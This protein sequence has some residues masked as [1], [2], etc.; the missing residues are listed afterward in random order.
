LADLNPVLVIDTRE[1]DPL[2]FTRLQSIKGTL[3]S[4]DYSV[5]GLESLIAIERKSVSDLVG[6]CI[7]RNR[8]RLERE[9]HRLRGFRFKRFLIVGTEE[10]ILRGNFQS[11]IKPKAVL[12]TLSAF[13]VRYDVPVVF[14]E[15]P[16]AAPR[17]IERWSFWFAR[18]V[19]KDANALP[20]A[21][22]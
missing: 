9:L 21:S 3:Y 12:A 22:T 20:K 17:Q 16:E 5:R 15:K 7:G 14:C 8:E 10:Q 6:C 4:G 1:Q 13:E 18:E 11:N 2:T 19:V